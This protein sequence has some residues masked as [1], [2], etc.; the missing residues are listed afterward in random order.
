MFDPSKKSDPSVLSAP[1]ALA[2]GAPRKGSEASSSSG[3]SVQ[4]LTDYGPLSAVYNL[5]IGDGGAMLLCALQDVAREMRN[6][7][8]LKDDTDDTEVGGKIGRSGKFMFVDNGILVYNER[9]EFLPAK[10]K[11]WLIRSDIALMAGS[12]FSVED[13]RR[14]YGQCLEIISPL[15]DK[16]PKEDP[17]ELLKKIEYL[18]SVASLEWTLLW[19]SGPE[20]KRV[21]GENCKKEGLFQPPMQ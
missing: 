1:E 4:R 3:A 20:E 14:L 11:Y 8:I 13:F 17:L 7:N 16:I 15:K 2:V 19:N 21:Q 5:E 6:R 18:E 10:R 12:E 9:S